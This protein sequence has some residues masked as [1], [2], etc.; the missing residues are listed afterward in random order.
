MK[1]LRSFR[2]GWD[3]VFMMSMDILQ[4]IALVLLYR[5]IS[6]A[7]V[8]IY[9]PMVGVQETALGINSYLSETGQLP[10]MT[11]GLS[12]TLEESVKA[13]QE[14]QLQLIAFVAACVLLF[15]LI[16]GIFRSLVYRRLSKKKYTRVFIILNSIWMVLWIAIFV[17]VYTAIHDTLALVLM[18][19]L[20]PVYL[21]L[22]AKMRNSVTESGIRI[23]LRRLYGSGVVNAHKHIIPALLVAVTFITLILLPVTDYFLPK[24]AVLFLIFVSVFLYLAWARSYYAVIA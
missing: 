3:T 9:S 11:D 2:F 17:F 14:F 23:S 1:Y 15:L 5:G 8:A 10:E 6:N 22:T 13:V 19:T 21:H 7:L 4:Y 20:V 16:S 18:F 24:Q 12:A